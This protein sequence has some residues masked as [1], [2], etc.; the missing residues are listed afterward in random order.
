[1][2]IL[3]LAGAARRHLAL[4]VALSTLGDVDYVQEQSLK[5]TTERGPA[6]HAYM[7]RMAEAEVQ[8]F[9]DPAPRIRR[10]EMVPFN[11]ISGVRLT[12]K[13]DYVLV[14]GTSWIRE[15]FVDDLIA[16][17]AIN[18][19]AGIAPEYRGTACNFWAEYDHRPDLVGTTLHY[20]SK[21][22]DTGPILERVFWCRRNDRSFNPHRPEC[23]PWT[24]SMEAVR[25]GHRRVVSMLALCHDYHLDLPQGLPQN[26]EHELRYTRAKDFTEDVCQ[27]FLN[28]WTEV[29]A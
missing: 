3:L 20:L 11:A 1:M 24:N 25:Q 13:Y 14:N 28:R 5:G 22:L 29:R 4:A 21:G 7:A 18:L 19:H 26:R 16:A 6:W 23:D 10:L 9:G 27:E 2:R 17:R 12:S 8:V 15:P